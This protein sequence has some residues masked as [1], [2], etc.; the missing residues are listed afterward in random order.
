MQGNF[1]TEAPVNPYTELALIFSASCLPSSTCKMMYNTEN[2]L[3]WFTEC[4]VN[5]QG[6]YTTFYRV[7]ILMQNIGL[8]SECKHEEARNMIKYIN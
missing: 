5:L 1:P 2:I 7:N 8:L 6:E 4:C 3:H